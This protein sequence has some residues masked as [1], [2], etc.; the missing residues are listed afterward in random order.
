MTTWAF[1]QAVKVFYRIRNKNKDHATF[2][3]GFGPS[4]LPHI[5]TVAEMLRTRMVIR[6]FNELTTDEHPN[7]HPE[8]YYRT[9][10]ILFA[11]DLDALRKVP[12][13]VPSDLVDLNDYIGVSV[14]D[15]PDPW[16]THDSYAAHN[17]G[18]L[19]RLLD[20]CGVSSNE[21]ELRRSSDFYRNGL[22]NDTIDKLARNA[23]E[24]ISIITHDYSVERQASYFPFLPIINGTVYQNVFNW[25]LHQDKLGEFNNRGCFSWQQEE[26][27]TTYL[28]PLSNGSVKCQ[29]KLDWPMRWLAFDVDFEMHG[30]DLI[31]SATVGRRICDLMG[32][33]PPV[34]FMYELFLDEQKQKISKS[35]GNGLEAD[36]WLTYGTIESL[37]YFLFQNPVKGRVLHWSCIPQ[38][39]D[40]YEKELRGSNAEPYSAI[41][42][43]HSSN[44]PH[45][46]PLTY[47]M[48]LN[49][50][51]ITDT[52]DPEVLFK[53]IGNYLPGV[54]IDSHKNLPTMVNGAIRYY[55]RFI[56]P[57]KMKKV[58]TQVEQEVL[59]DL[60]QV[61]ARPLVGE[62]TIRA[63]IYEV[64]K[65]HYGA[66]QLTYFFKMLYQVLLGQESG[67]Q[68][69]Q[70]VE[71]VGTEKVI[72]MIKEL[73]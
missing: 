32:H 55:Q 57:N 39:V 10:W 19:V 25:R 33:E 37:E 46:A 2:E 28:T 49:L 69:H 21:Y 26:G 56:L 50:V 13:N 9:Q 31:G 59:M 18:E 63:N 72:A 3:C 30:K 44:L 48:L 67:P 5:G 58:P 35:K 15:I 11:D 36:E 23:N 6:A 12:E 47:S 66:D 38:Y 52:E 8:S 29:W 51:A 27:Q 73:V 45:N 70:F 14:C 53:Y 34:I 64:G 68:F 42:T 62:D 7:E 65:S 71:V 24:L 40:L 17:I 16:G 1:D 4:G 60:A 61:L 54:N 43:I 20:R 41:W 22:F